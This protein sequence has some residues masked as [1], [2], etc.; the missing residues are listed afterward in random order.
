[1]NQSLV[2]ALSCYRIL[3]RRGAILEA[4]AL[5]E[6][7]LEQQ[8]GNCK[9]TLWGLH[10]LLLSDLGDH[11]LALTSFKTA[12]SLAPLMD[13]QKLVQAETYLANRDFEL[14]RAMFLD[15]E[16]HNTISVQQMH[17]LALGLT[18]TGLPLR[19][20]QICRDAVQREIGGPDL[21]YTMAQLMNGLG[22][23]PSAV[24]SVLKVAVS[25]APDEVKYRIG[26][27]AH[28]ARFKDVSEGYQA[29]QNLTPR[30]IGRLDCRRCV[31]FLRWIY[32]AVGDEELARGCRK[33]EQHC[34]LQRCHGDS[35]CRSETN[36]LHLSSQIVDRLCEQQAFEPGRIDVGD[37]E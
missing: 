23:S 5:L 1:M 2:D 34:R 11:Q 33:R 9:A 29:I 4:R 20:L 25:L 7:L 26:L 36:P 17:R 13:D 21:Y 14:A 18:K 10:G 24:L 30:Q 8:T 35:C 27:A 12:S 3:Y 28:L 31:G 37:L 6:E 16:N 32:E 22:H 15:L 19:A